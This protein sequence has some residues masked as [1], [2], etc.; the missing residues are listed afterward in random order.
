[1]THNKTRI[2]KGTRVKFELEGATITG[3]V[4]H[5]MLHIENGRKMAVIELENELPG[6]TKTVPFNE[7][8]AAPLREYQP[9]KII[10][11]SD[12]HQQPHDTD[13]RRI[14]VFN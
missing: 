1:M 9:L 8:T 7:L 3:T 12:E 4:F 5:I 10:Y 11:L 14:V 6:T 2:T 13:D